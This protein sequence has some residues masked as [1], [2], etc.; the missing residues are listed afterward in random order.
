VQCE[1]RI[2]QLTSVSR[3]DRELGW[4]AANLSQ[5][6]EGKRS[7]KLSILI[8]SDCVVAR[9]STD[10]LVIEDPEV[11]EIVRQ[12]RHH[13]DEVFGVERILRLSPLSRRQLEHRFRRSVGSSPYAFLN[14]LRV[15]RAKLLLAETHKRTLT[16][17]ARECGFS[18]LRRFRMVFRRLTKWSPADYRRRCAK[19]S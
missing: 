7:L 15:E 14:E 4:Q 18:E 13:L 9:Q 12:I 6:L 5:L 1:F 3:N 16:T 17:V 8:P 10:T 11:A 2:P 19:P